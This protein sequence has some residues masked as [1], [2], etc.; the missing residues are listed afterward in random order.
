MI[1]KEFFEE[2]FISKDEKNDRIDIWLSKQFKEFSRSKIQEAIKNQKVLLNGASCRAKDT[3][4]ADDHI[5]LLEEFQTVKNIA[6][7]EEYK[8]NLDF[9]YED[10]DL[11]VVNKPSGIS[12]HPSIS[13]G[14]SERSL[15]EA[16]LTYCNGKTQWSS[17]PDFSMRPGVVHR[18]DKETTGALVW[19]KDQ[20]TLDHL[21]KQFKEKTNFRQYLA[22]LDGDLT[23]KTIILESYLTRDPKNK[24]RFTSFH[25]DSLTDTQKKQMKWAKTVFTKKTNFAHKYCLCTVKLHTGRTHQIRVHAKECGF[26]ILGDPV[27]NRKKTLAKHLSSEVKK[28]IENISRQM[29]HAHKLGFIHPSTNKYMEFT[30]K[31]PSDFEDLLNALKTQE[32]TGD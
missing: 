8:L 28:K 22:L 29:L 18:L 17:Q 15:I 4:K 1:K 10:K 21:S 6:A 20:K 13:Q 9:L 25:S 11:I 23:E 24:T 3:I 7:F 14:K 16:L 32:I 12:V 30:A 19:A 2:F 5:I 31:I 26:P 27:Y